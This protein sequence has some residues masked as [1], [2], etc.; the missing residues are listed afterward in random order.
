M[1]VIPGLVEMHAHLPRNGGELGANALDYVYRVYLGHG[2]TT[3]R[4]A[5]TGAGIETMAEQR[6]LSDGNQVVAPRLVLCQR[7]PLP[8]RRWDVGDTPEEARAMVQRFKQLGADCIKVSK[9]PGHFPDVLEAIVAE[10]KK[11]D[12]PTMVDLKVS[13][14]DARVA[15]MAGVNSIEH[16]YGIP[17]AALQGSQSYPSDYNYWDELDRFRYAGKLWAEAD[18]HPDRIIEV[19]ETMIANGTA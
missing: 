7:W 13:E 11:L 3:V 10:G 2:V 8:L 1:Y 9:S 19:L 15:S 4:D 18:A 6:R 5:G 17:D 14:T 12:M 16:W